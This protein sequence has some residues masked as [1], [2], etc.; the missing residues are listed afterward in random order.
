M[1]QRVRESVHHSGSERKRESF[2]ELEKELVR[3]REKSR[4]ESVHH[5]PK[6]LAVFQIQKR[7]VVHF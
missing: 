1:T 6:S 3:G 5:S 2:R 7:T 4:S